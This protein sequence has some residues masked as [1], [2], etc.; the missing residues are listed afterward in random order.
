MTDIYI[1]ALNGTLKS[2]GQKSSTKRNFKIYNDLPIC[3]RVAL[4]THTGTIIRVEKTDMIS[5]NKNATIKDSFL[6]DGSFLMVNSAHTG[7]FIGILIIKDSEYHITTD[8]L[9]KPG[10][11]GPVPIPTKNIPVPASSQN[12]VVGVGEVQNKKGHSLMREQ[13]WQLAADSYTLFPKEKKNIAVTTTSGISQTTTESKEISSS[14]GVSASIGYGAFSAS[15]SSSLNTTSSYMQSYTITEQK[16]TYE[17]NEIINNNDYPI[18]YLRWQI[19]DV[20]NIYHKSNHSDAKATIVV[21]LE[22]SILKSY[23]QDKIFKTE[24]ES[25]AEISYKERVWWQENFLI[26]ENDNKS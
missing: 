21:L 15:I 9:C 11:I 17:S 10:D 13:S 20:V 1:Q 24:D 7:G 2:P 12:I 22:P 23:D 8:M 3:V 4:I 6:S 19:A 18:M 5:P 16:S 26:S 25:V 14:L